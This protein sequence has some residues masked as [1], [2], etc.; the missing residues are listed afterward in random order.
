MDVHNK[1]SIYMGLCI[2]ITQIT[3]LHLTHTT[4]DS[5]DNVTSLGQD[6]VATK[7]MCGPLWLLGEN[8]FVVDHISDISKLHLSLYGIFLAYMP[9]NA[10]DLIQADYRKK[11]MKNVVHN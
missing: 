10:S 11:R 2:R 7:T 8:L 4:N 9:H 6:I 5:C 1:A 3:S